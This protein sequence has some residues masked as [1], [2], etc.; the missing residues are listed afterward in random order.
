LNEG[1]CAFMIISLS[2]LRRMRNV[3]DKTCTENENTHFLSSN[4]I[5]PKIVPFMR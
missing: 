2:A 1:L 3:S 4:F 5:F